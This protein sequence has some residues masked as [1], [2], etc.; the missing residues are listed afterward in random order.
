MYR[1]LD[2]WLSARGVDDD[3]CTQSQIA[4]LDQVLG[5]L[6]RAHSLALEACVCGVLER[7]V[8]ALVV[9]VHGDNLL[10]S[11]GFGDSAAQQTDRSCT[12][13][14]D[15]VTRLDGSLPCDVNSDSSRLNKRTLFH[16]HVLRKLVAVVLWQAVI[17]R[18]RAIVWGS[19][20]K[21]HVG[22]KVVLALLAA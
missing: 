10:R 20:C 13:Y 14:D 4:L 2:A 16:T 21:S 17:P 7:E 11:V 5:V 15:R 1:S 9:D 12:E 3:I 8:E 6:L 22:A 18:K 19:C